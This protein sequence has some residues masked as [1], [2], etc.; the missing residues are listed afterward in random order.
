MPNIGLVRREEPGKDS[1]LR[2]II[3][4]LLLTFSGIFTASADPSP[5]DA[6]LHNSRTLLSI[7]C[8][9]NID[10]SKPSNSPYSVTSSRFTEE[11]NALKTAGFEFVSQEQVEAFYLSGKP[12]PPKSALITFDD[13]HLNIYERA[14]PILKRMNI[15][16]ILFVFPTAI[17][18]GHEQGFMDWN[19]VRTLHGDGVAIGCHSYDHPYLTRPGKEI[20]TPEAYETWLDK[21]LAHSRRLIEERLGSMVNSFAAPFG[22]LNS[23]SQRH[24]ASSGYSLAFNVFGSNNDAM[25]DRLELN[26]TIV[27][28]S[29]TAE[30]VVKKA[31]ERP[32]HFTKES[33]GALQV[34]GGSLTTVGF[35][36]ANIE[37]YIPGSIY[38]IFN[39]TR[40]E[41]LRE[42]GASFSFDIPLPDR[43]KGF[44]VTANARDLSGA[45]CSQSY[46]FIYAPVKP[47]F[48]W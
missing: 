40:I 7:L 13:G 14:Y 17:G 28:A 39:G 20:S 12:L 23:V 36:I 37:N 11:L 35:S 19:D 15:P 9:H 26:R 34:V 47:L 29:D 42:N 25:N 8:Y 32:L 27:L 38:V 1:W 5:R 44:I 31:S 3:V 43:G 18:A 22:A 16:W 24:I 2:T 45:P 48:L 6:N 30:T 41:P 46:Y 4:V 10:L 33:P 21:E